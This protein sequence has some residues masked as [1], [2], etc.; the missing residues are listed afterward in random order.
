M[1]T[2]T[3][4]FALHF[5]KDLLVTYA[6]LKCPFGRVNDFFRIVGTCNGLVCLADDQDTYT[7]RVIIWNPCAKKSVNLPKPMFPYLP[8]GTAL[9]G[10]GFDSVNNDYK[11]V[12]IVYRLSIPGGHHYHVPPKVEIYALSTKVWRSICDVAPMYDIF[13]YFPS[14]AFVSGHLHWV[15]SRR[16]ENGNFH[17][18]LSGFD[19][20]NEVFR[21][22]MVPEILAETEVLKLAV[23]AW[24]KSL[25]LVQYEKIWQ[26][27]YCWVWKMNEYNVVESWAR[28][29]MIDM[30][31]GIRKV[32]NLQRTN[33]VIMSA[34]AKGLIT[35][36]PNTKQIKSLGIH[37]TNRSLFMDSFVESLVL[38]EAGNRGLLELG[39]S[40]T[41]VVDHHEME[42]LVLGDDTQIHEQ[43]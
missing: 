21:E 24:D 3:E 4:R 36:H 15:A 20:N 16:R 40:S 27:E 29:F 1:F 34:R 11:V 13:N 37:G 14:P 19:M 35:Y 26:S 17:N 33:E 41:G 12:R 10:F 5:E 38:V 31:E 8:Q 25:A 39:S 42:N 7:D 18:F 30:R 23:L 28:L 9:L 6:E 43:V 32:V 22:V 2:E